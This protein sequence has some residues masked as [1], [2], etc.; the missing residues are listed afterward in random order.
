MDTPK[1]AYWPKKCLL[2]EKVP[3]DY[4]KYLLNEN[5]SIDC[6]CAYWMKM[7]LLT[8]KMPVEKWKSTTIQCL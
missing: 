7:C 3:V 4:K 5:V 1:G 8:E 2:N 6:K